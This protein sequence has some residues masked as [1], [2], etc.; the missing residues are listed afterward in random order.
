[1]DIST[2][3]SVLVNREIKSNFVTVLTRLFKSFTANCVL[4]DAFLVC[5]KT[6]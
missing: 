4:H 5:V 3:L 2:K 1:M 6:E